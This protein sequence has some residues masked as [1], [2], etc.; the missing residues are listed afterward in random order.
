[1]FQS[2]CSSLL[3][4]FPPESTMSIDLA[5]P[6]YLSKEE[7]GYRKTP[8]P[9]KPCLNSCLRFEHSHCVDQIESKDGGS[10]DK[11]NKKAKKQVSFA[12]H[13]GLSLTK[14]K[15][16]SE[17]ND[18]IGIPLNIQQ[19]LNS[20]L[21][22]AKEDKLVLD[23]TQP[24]SDYLQ[25]RQHLENNY[26][27]LEHCM[28][29]ENAMAGTIKVKNRSFEKSVKLRVTFD[30][31]KSHK[32]VACLY[33]KDTYPGSSNDTFSFEVVLPDQLRPHEHI[34][35]AICYEV[36]G[37]MYWDS[38]QGKNY[39]IIWSSRRRMEQQ[40]HSFDLGIHF[41]RYGSPTCSHGLFPDWPSY[42]GYE[43]IGPYY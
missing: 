9:C 11:E 39:R 18:P 8:K 43:N 29:R 42:A 1:M 40:R 21:T 12:D 17:F 32:D 2:S 19:M 14:V 38:N 7:F 27:C 13:K 26:V 37:R 31:W 3:G 25:F 23:F 36:D 33:M 10:P 34:E 5:I 15:V 24:S 20:S 6:L 28:L 16:F 30:T 4:L 35:F 41:D 22:S